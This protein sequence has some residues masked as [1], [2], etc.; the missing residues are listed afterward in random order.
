MSVY[1]TQIVY[2]E[3]IDCKWAGPS[4]VKLMHSRWKGGG[5]PL[6]SYR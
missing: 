5:R 6:T 2:E 4:A 1:W 3:K